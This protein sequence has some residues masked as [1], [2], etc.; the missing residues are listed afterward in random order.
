MV[1][2]KALLIALPCLLHTASAV[3]WW[4]VDFYEKGCTDSGRLNGGMTTISGNDTESVSPCLG[5]SVYILN[6][7]PTKS[8]Q[9]VD[10]RSVSVHG[11][12]G[13]DW[14]VDFY[15]AYDCPKE[16]LVTSVTEDDCYSSS[17][18]VS[19]KPSG[20][21][22]FERRLTGCLGSAQLCHCAK[23]LIRL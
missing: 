6:D 14:V 12:S 17:K 2:L 21:S 20:Y 8:G 23:S 3:K 18:A 19:I 16:S 11:V 13:T 15:A 9:E 1:S 10:A 4:Y 5:G 7:D 22:R